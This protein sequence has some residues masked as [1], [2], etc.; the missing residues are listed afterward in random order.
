MTLPHPPTV[1]L[2]PKRAIRIFPKT[3]GPDDLRVAPVAL[4]RRSMID[5]AL[6]SAP[7]APHSEASGVFRLLYCDFCA[8][9]TRGASTGIYLRMA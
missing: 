2:I 8:A 3:W 6:P 7:H 4:L 9:V 1:V 5:H